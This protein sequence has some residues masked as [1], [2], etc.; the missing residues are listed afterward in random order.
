MELEC[1][2]RVFNNILPKTFCDEVID[3]VKQKHKLDRAITLIEQNN[4]TSKEAKAKSS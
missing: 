1:C 2:Y 3:Y 4:P